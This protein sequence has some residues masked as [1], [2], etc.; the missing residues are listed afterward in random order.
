[1]TLEEDNDYSI[2]TPWPNEHNLDIL[3]STLLDCDS[4]HNGG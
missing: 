1:M 4:F 3:R 2:Y